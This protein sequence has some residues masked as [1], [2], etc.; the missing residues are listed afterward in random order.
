MSGQ[1]HWLPYRLPGDSPLP[2]SCSLLIEC[3]LPHTGIRVF[4]SIP[5]ASSLD[6]IGGPTILLGLI[7]LAT[8]DHTMYAAVKVLHSVLTSSVMC[9]RLMQHISGYQV[10]PPSQG[11]VLPREQG[12]ASLAL[13]DLSSMAT[14]REGKPRGKGL[15]TSVTTAGGQGMARQRGALIGMRMFICTSVPF[16]EFKNHCGPP[17]LHLT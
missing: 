11:A 6:F 5:A 14:S 2:Q 4:H 13:V 8:D 1:W 3:P 7:S 9:D 12:R 16:N 15:E 10:I 17:T